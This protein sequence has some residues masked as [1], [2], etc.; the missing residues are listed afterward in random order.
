MTGKSSRGFDANWPSF[1]RDCTVHHRNSIGG[2]GT[3]MR[4]MARWMPNTVNIDTVAHHGAS[5]QSLTIWPSLFSLEPLV[6]IEERQ[7]V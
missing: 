4:A 6:R 3:E 5:D 2:G 1:L 7:Y